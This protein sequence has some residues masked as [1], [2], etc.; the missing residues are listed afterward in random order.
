MYFP[1]PFVAD[2]FA[3]GSRSISFLL[4]VGSCV[5]E[6]YLSYGCVSAQV[7][8]AESEGTTFTLWEYSHYLEFVGNRSNKNITVK[9]KLCLSDKCLS[10]VKSSTSN[11]KKHYA[12]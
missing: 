2:I 12:S 10:A 3:A 8:M 11:L 5:V 4:L 6:G 1:V 7:E 9:C